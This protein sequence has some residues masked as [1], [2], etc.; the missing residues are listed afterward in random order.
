MTNGVSS[1]CAY[2]VSFPHRVSLTGLYSVCITPFISRAS[3]PSARG[4]N[5]VVANDTQLTIATPH[6]VWYDGK[7]P[8]PGVCSPLMKAGFPTLCGQRV[9]GDS[10]PIAA[11]ATCHYPTPRAP[12]A[13]AAP[14]GGRLS[15]AR[16]WEK[17]FSGPKKLS[18]PSATHCRERR[19]K[20]P[21]VLT[22][23]LM[24]KGLRPA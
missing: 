22:I 24:K 17:T 5:R 9:R 4:P 21:A 15:P 6:R 16:F 19:K 20:T 3:H 8:R 7:Q 12:V 23:D 2:Q 13:C 1:C 11:S 10:M 18:T 14:A